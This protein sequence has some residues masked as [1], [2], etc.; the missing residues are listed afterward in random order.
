M[1]QHCTD[2]H[3][4]SS[5]LIFCISDRIHALT[6]MYRTWSTLLLKVISSCTLRRRI[7]ESLSYWDSILF[8][9]QLST[10]W[11]NI[12]TLTHQRQ[13]RDATFTDLWS[14]I[15]IQPWDD[16]SKGSKQL[17]DPDFMSSMI[18]QVGIGDVLYVTYCQLYCRGVLPWSSTIVQPFIQ[19]RVLWWSFQW[20]LLYRKRI[21]NKSKHLSPC[22]I[23]FKLTSIDGSYTFQ[24]LIYLQSSVSI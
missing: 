2:L 23:L 15:T 17:P 24:E 11:R 3:L 20:S 9:W 7:T 8:L 10:C 5:H 18:H 4:I 14:S 1:T 16:V 6:L 22:V 13:S 19:Q 12:V 21:T